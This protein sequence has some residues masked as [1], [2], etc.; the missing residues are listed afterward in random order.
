MTAKQFLKKKEIKPS[1]VGNIV[2]WPKYLEDLMEEY[3]KEK[4][5]PGTY[6]SKSVWAKVTEENKSLKRDIYD[7]LVVGNPTRG[8]VSKAYSLRAQ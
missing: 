5:P 4:F 1:N 6:V 3:V 2:I 8:K 7:M